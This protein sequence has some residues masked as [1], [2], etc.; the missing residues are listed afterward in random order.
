MVVYSEARETILGNTTIYD[1]SVASQSRCKRSVPLLVKLR[2][3][4]LLQA[5][6]TEVFDAIFDKGIPHDKLKQKTT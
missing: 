6:T 5:M 1:I 4:S 3:S 2:L